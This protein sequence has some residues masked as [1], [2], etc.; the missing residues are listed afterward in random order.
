M[1]PTYFKKGQI[2][3]FADKFLHKQE[4][5]NKAIVI[6]NFPKEKTIIVKII[7]AFSVNDLKPFSVEL[8]CPLSYSYDDIEVLNLNKENDVYKEI[9]LDLI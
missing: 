6:K 2:I 4:Y 1:K 3:V 9:E 7:S 8:D 5:A